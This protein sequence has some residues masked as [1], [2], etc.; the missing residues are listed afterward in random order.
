MSGFGCP[1]CLRSRQPSET[2]YF[3][4][5]RSTVSYWPPLCP[6]FAHIIGWIPRLSS[7]FVRVF[8][9]KVVQFYTLFNGLNSPRQIVLSNSLTDDIW[10]CGFQRG[11]TDIPVCLLQPE[12]DQSARQTWQPHKIALLSSFPLIAVLIFPGPR[13]LDPKGALTMEWVTPQHEE[14]ELNCEISSYANA[15]L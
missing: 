6:T 14:I 11:G 1:K 15:E 3:V 5:L 13:N 9:K 12:G 2:F 8:K 10:W 7:D 4:L